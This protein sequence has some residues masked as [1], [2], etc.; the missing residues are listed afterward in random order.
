MQSF[1]GL[2]Y[3]DVRV[4]FNSFIPADIEEEMGGRL[5]KLLYEQTNIAA[6]GPR[7]SRV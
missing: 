3:V 1:H 7:Q 5:V 6:L 4:S 2:P